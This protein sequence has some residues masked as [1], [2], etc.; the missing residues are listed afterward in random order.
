V[1]CRPAAALAAVALVPV[2]LWAGGR[3]DGPQIQPAV[4]ATTPAAPTIRAVGMVGCAAAACHGGPGVGSLT[5]P[6][7]A[8]CWQTAATHWRAVDP[9]TRAYATLGGERSARI[10]ATLGRKHPAARDVQCLACHTNPALAD[11]D[12]DPGPERLALRAEG[13]GCEACH[14]NAGRWQAVHT[15]DGADGVGF[16]MVPLRDLGARALA[17]AGCHVGAPADPARGYP[18]RDV[19]HDLLAAGHP[20]LTFEF[21][22]YQLRLTP[23]W[24]EKDRTG[25]GFEAK[26]WLAGRAATAE[27]ACRLLADRAARGPWPELAEFNC[28][29]C[30]HDLPSGRPSPG[31]AP[32]QTVWPLTRPVD[33]ADWS[34]D[35]TEPREAA[36]GMEALLAV[37]R[38]P[39]PPPAARVAK[40]A[41][42]AAH[43]FMVLRLRLPIVSD[44]DAVRFARQA[45]DRVPAA[46][47]DWDEA[48]QRVHGLAALERARAER[49][50]APA[51]FAAAFDRLTLP[52]RFDS[53]R[54]YDPAAAGRLVADLA[55]AVREE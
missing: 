6:P 25:S 15:R 17:C 24:H 22:D 48:C 7:A 31:T 41:A 47:P 26:A 40:P 44:A 50:P 9:H 35:V 8:D 11:A 1:P 54:G 20:R 32:W 27:A 13:V 55:R 43:R 5:G 51:A 10:M 39:R 38:T 34:D 21:A 49:R 30:H 29:A 18:V 4:F 3:A 52:R 53:P 14:G 28:A 45:F 23:H 42:D 37:F 46:I 33:F 36:A 12:P 16:G 2:A 19:N